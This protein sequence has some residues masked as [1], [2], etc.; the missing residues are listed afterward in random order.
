MNK[1]KKAAKTL[2]KIRY[3]DQKDVNPRHRFNE[4]DDHRDGSRTP[5]ERNKLK[6]LEKTNKKKYNK[7]KNKLPNYMFYN[8]EHHIMPK[9]NI[10]KSTEKGLYKLL[11]WME[12]MTRKGYN[13][14][15]SRIT[16][17]ERCMLERCKD[18]K[19]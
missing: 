2:E 1:R 4:Y 17:K 16:G 12:K 11:K 7:L 8:E 5:I 3:E 18:R 13:F 15:D 6:H 9:D 19:R 10:K 14:L